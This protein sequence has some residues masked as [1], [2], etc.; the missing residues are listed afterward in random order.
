MTSQMRYFLPF[1]ARRRSG[2]A[3]LGL[4]VCLARPVAMG[5]D[6]AAPTPASP[7]APTPAVVRVFNR[8]V[9]I[10]R[11]LNYGYNPQERAAHAE[12][13]IRELIQA[14]P[15]GEVGAHPSM[16]GTAITIGG[17]HAFTITPA[18][19]DIVEGQTQEQAAQISVKE[20]QAAVAGMQKQH[21]WPFLIQ[22]SLYSLGATAIFALL[23]W[24]VWRIEM[25]VRPRLN[26]QVR[27]LGE[28]LTKGGHGFLSRLSALIRSLARLVTWVVVLASAY[29]WLTFCLEQFPYTQ[30]WGESL[31]RFLFTSLSGLV[32]SVVAAL[33]DLFVVVVIALV[34]RLLGRAVRG[35]FGAIQKGRMV[36]EWMDPQAAKATGRLAV[37]VIWIF[38]AVMMYP[39][40][41]GSG[42][43]AFRGVSVFVGL[44]VSL[45]ASS[46]VGQ[47]TGGLVLMYSKALK[48]GEY[49]RA[50]ESEGTVTSVGFLSTKILT[51]WREEIH[52][53]NLMLLN[54]ALKNYSR[55]ADEKGVIIKTSVTIGYGTPWRQVHGLLLEA[56]K[57]TAGL[58]QQPVPFVLQRALGDF[59]VEYQLNVTLEDPPQRIFVL[60]ELRTHIQ[61]LFNEYGVQILSP[62]YLQDP[63][64]KVVVPREQWFAAPAAPEPA[65][66]AR[67][68]KEKA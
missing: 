4:L 37:V 48:P 18:D 54:T 44:L 55:V 52:L 57:R 51:P 2:R 64:K 49:V 13:R 6:A 50:G 3:L 41:P 42:S 56:A 61:D 66:T 9:A 47:F 11:G 67:A 14:H 31:G 15:T 58:G 26:R 60:S 34:A 22:A 62:H 63:P 20:L 28:Y 36:V 40:L 16:E 59:Y 17:E 46:V 24:A 65:G 5:A 25:W 45:G 39:Y 27:R 10:L 19:V 8:P 29:V 35:F 21:E 23:I 12:E 7:P 1:F 30:P 43:Q 53:P 38:A 68:Q 33:P 32:G